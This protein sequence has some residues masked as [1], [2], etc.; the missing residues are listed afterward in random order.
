MELNQANMKS[1]QT[2]ISLLVITVL[3]PAFSCNNEKKE[4]EE[5][6]TANA[7]TRPATQLLFDKL[8]GTWKIEDGKSF[9]EWKKKDDGTYQSRVYSIKLKDTAWNEQAAIYP[10][11]GNWVFENTVKDQNEGKAIKFT[12]T[13]L[14]DNSVQFSNPAHDFP[15]DINYT[16]TDANTVHTF[17]VGP[18]NKGGKDTI[19][20]NY[21]RL[22]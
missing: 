21:T 9:E 20:F 3:V 14:S 7:N 2:S 11:G 6:K 4:N 5:S 18:N 17:I 13:I 15:T 1:I 12:S 22:R 16:V 19:P 8:V 10:E